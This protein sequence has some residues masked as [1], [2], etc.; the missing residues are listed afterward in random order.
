MWEILLNHGFVK[1]AYDLLSKTFVIKIHE[2]DLNY[3]YANY[4]NITDNHVK[5]DCFYNERTDVLGVDVEVYM[6]YRYFILS[7]LLYVYAV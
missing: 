1:E 3:V 7:V 2:N 5:I 6:R 4:Q